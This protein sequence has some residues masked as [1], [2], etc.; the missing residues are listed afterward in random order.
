MIIIS[1]LCDQLYICRLKISQRK[2]VQ[3]R[4]LADG[5]NLSLICYYIDCPHLRN[6]ETVKNI[7]CTLKVSFCISYILNCTKQSREYMLTILKQFPSSIVSEWWIHE[8]LMQNF[9]V[10]ILSYLLPKYKWWCHLT[11]LTSGKSSIKC[12]STSLT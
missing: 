10:L 5:T 3:E 1:E 11:L 12:S 2:S 9:I 6:E 7:D 8:D 4:K